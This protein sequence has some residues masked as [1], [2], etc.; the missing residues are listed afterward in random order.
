MLDAQ[1]FLQSYL[2]NS[3]TVCF[4]L[5]SMLNYFFGLSSYLATQY[6]L[7]YARWSTISTASARTCN[8]ICFFTCSTISSALSRNWQR[9][10]FYGLI[11]AHI[12]LQS[13]FVPAIQCFSTCSMFNYFFGLSSYLATHSF[14]SH[15]G[16]S[17]VYRASGPNLQWIRVWIIL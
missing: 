3:N 13:Q 11:D 17:D 5:C 1:L 10:L 6:V 12:F 8:I 15:A 9:T 16:C 4:I 14:V 2:V 7:L